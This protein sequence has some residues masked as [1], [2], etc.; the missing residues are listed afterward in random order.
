MSARARCRARILWVATKVVVDALPRLLAHA[1]LV[2]P[3]LLD[4][5]VELV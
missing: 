5:L 3:Q 1:A 4:S 2:A